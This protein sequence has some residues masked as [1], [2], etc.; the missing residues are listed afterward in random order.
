[1]RLLSRLCLLSLAFTCGAV[2]AAE[3]DGKPA[4]PATQLAG[5]DR[6]I[7]PGDDFYTYANGEWLGTHDI[8]QDRAYYSTDVALAELNEQRIAELIRG[9]SASGTFTDAET[10]KIADYY[11]SFMDEPRIE[12]A[13]LT[14][15]RP[16]LDRIAAINDRTSLAR[17]LGGTMRSDVDVLNATHLAT[18]RL[19]GLWVA[20]DLDDPSRYL[21][22]LLQGGLGM[23]DRDYYLKDSPEMVKDRA[24][25]QKY[26]A[27]ILKLAD[28]ADAD[29]K[30][31]RIFQL[32]RRMASVHASLEASE[33]VKL[34]DNHWTR[35]Q[36]AERAP[37]IDWQA[38]LGAAGLERQR[39]FIVWQPDAFKGLAALV[40]SEPIE[41]WKA[42]LTFQELSCFAPY[43]PRAFVAARFA[44]YGT[45]LSGTPINRERWKLAIQATDDA[46]GDAVGKLYVQRYFP[47]AAKAQIEELVQHL[48][49]A[50]SARIDQLEWMAPATREKARAKLATLK[51]SVGYPDHWRDY[52]T[53]EIRR[54]DLLGNVQRAEL[55]EYHRNL[56]KLSRPVDRSEWVMLAQQV[57][58][59]NLPAM[60]ALN[61]P[62][63]ILQPPYFDPKQ[64]ASLNYAQVGATIGHEISHS[65]DDQGALFDSTGRLQNWWTD[66]D[67]ARFR[68]S[69]RQLVAQYNAYRPFEDLAING[70]QDLSE[71]IA[72]LAGLAA[73][74]S[75]YRLSLDGTPAPEVEGLSGDQQFFVAFA[76]SWR[77]K[78]R[79]ASL[80]KQ[81][82]SDGHAPS[83]YRALTVRNLDAWYAAFDVKPGQK[84]Y[85]N[86]QD[87][88]HVW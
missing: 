51:V 19:F 58:A 28:V 32:E 64:P 11:N 39:S 53:L 8:P 47:P 4:A 63:A 31:D 85:L 71:N 54:G 38:Y 15:L 49:E 66:A 22:F 68:A 80:R 36:L 45:T 30:A 10:R 13:G 9:I 17:Y 87:R 21:P 52:A 75:A 24:G 29:A 26:I 34:G 48:I 18:P 33:D 83:Q 69:A 70:Q 73:A 16:T 81:I 5:M 62:A 60:N 82:I 41:T 76:Q 27:T 56:A 40:S 57:N 44:F 37:G 55:F 35:E 7:V 14:G 3:Q 59:V 77:E 46:L 20:Q 74:Y 23:P 50:F 72:D 79:D 6:A 42:Y 78:A 43:L 86:P 2:A 65:F 1:M 12:A 67:L 25:Y 88:V 84:L 61:F